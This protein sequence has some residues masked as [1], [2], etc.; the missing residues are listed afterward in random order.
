[1]TTTE[2]PSRG[3]VLTAAAFGLYTFVF[4]PL[5]ALILLASFLLIGCHV[6]RF[7]KAPAP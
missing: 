5:T 3:N 7:G 2:L 4:T 1:M 6:Q